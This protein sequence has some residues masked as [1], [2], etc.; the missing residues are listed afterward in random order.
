MFKLYGYVPNLKLLKVSFDEEK[1]INEISR[2]INDV[3]YIHFMI[4]LQNENSMI[5]Y[6]MILNE[7]EYIEY[8][9]EYNKN[10]KRRVL[11]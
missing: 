11:K 3:E 8:L 5:P 7:K 10:N 6:R 4:V 1:I 2:R 9:E